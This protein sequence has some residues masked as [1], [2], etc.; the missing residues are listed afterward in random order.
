M[1][2]AKIYSIAKAL[3]QMPRDLIKNVCIC[4][5]ETRIL[6]FVNKSIRT[7]SENSFRSLTTGKLNKDLET[8]MEL[9]RLLRTRQDLKLRMKYVPNDIGVDGMYCASKLA[10]KASDEAT[11]EYNRQRHLQNTNANE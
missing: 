9:N 1:N 2:H 6:T 8:S 3:Q 10:R 7:M 5:D 11:R 4:V